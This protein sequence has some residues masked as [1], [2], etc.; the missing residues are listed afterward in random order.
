MKRKILFCLPQEGQKSIKVTSVERLPLFHVLSFGLLALWFYNGWIKLLYGHPHT[1]HD[2][3]SKLIGWFVSSYLHQT[4]WHRDARSHA[5]CGVFLLSISHSTSF[6]SRQS[7]NAS[8][9]PVWFSFTR[10]PIPYSTHGYQ[11]TNIWPPWATWSKRRLF[12]IFLMINNY[13]FSS[14]LKSFR[15][16]WLKRKCVF[17]VPYLII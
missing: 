17:L 2:A 4:A 14:M 9:I 7:H 12:Y 10:L 15:L 8:Q 3:H 11:Q 16:E 6:F 5:T 13:D 1:S